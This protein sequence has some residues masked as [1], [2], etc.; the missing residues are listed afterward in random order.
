MIHKIALALLVLAYAGIAYVS[1]RPWNLANQPGIDRVALLPPRADQAKLRSFLDYSGYILPHP[2]VAA[3]PAGA[4]AMLGYSYRE[5]SVLRLPFFAYADQGIVLYR[6]LPDHYQAVPLDADYRALLEKEAG[7][8]LGR[9]YS[10]P[11]WRYLWGWLFAA[12]L[13][14]CVVL[15]Q[16]AVSRRREALGLM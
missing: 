12:G 13:I 16:R 4:P 3:G 2:P 10:F 5:V 15:E 7:A 6:D 1:N 9:D 11:F 14:L 8:P